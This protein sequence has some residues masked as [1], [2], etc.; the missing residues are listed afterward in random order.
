M[1][2][3]LKCSISFCY[4][5]KCS[6]D[7]WLSVVVTFHFCAALYWTIL[8]TQYTVPLHSVFFVVVN[9]SQAN[10]PLKRQK[11]CQK[12]KSKNGLWQCQLPVLVLLLS[13]F[14]IPEPD[15]VVTVLCCIPR[16]GKDWSPIMMVRACKRREVSICL[17][18]YGAIFLL[19][20]LF[21]LTFILHNMDALEVRTCFWVQLLEVWT[22]LEM[23]HIS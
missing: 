21:V 15:E 1:G 22:L 18:E 12:A 16:R 13:L 14:F 6:N 20:A 10:K 9:N 23:F 2:I 11:E 5:N 8:A 3:S 7:N 19:L 4:Q 17:P